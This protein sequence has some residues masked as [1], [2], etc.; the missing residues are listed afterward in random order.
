[1]VPIYTPP[2]PGRRKM[3][4]LL[5][6]DRSLARSVVPFNYAD[7]ETVVGENCQE[8]LEYAGCIEANNSA[9]QQFSFRGDFV[10]AAQRR[11]LSPLV[12]REVG[13]YAGFLSL[14]FSPL[15]SAS[16]RLHKEEFGPV[17]ANGR[18]P[19]HFQNPEG[20]EG[21]TLNS[22]VAWGRRRFVGS[23]P[24]DPT[25]GLSLRSNASIQR[26]MLARGTRVLGRFRRTHRSA[27]ISSSSTGD[28]RSRVSKVIHHPNKGN[29][30]TLKKNG[31][32]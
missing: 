26:G 29:G 10:P 3:R 6:R 16:D 18:G 13:L 24:S 5:R 9:E 25:R 30:A 4:S 20:G 23:T 31:W 32:G 1:M 14:S 19:D 2:G 7:H 22:T 8:E 21:K 27:R 17:S 12:G 11:R 15:C 28:S